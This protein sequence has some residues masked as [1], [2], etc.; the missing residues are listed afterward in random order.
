MK[1][2]FRIIFNYHRGNIKLYIFLMMIIF[3]RYY[4]KLPTPLG[5]ILK[6]FGLNYWSQHMTTAFIYILKGNFYRA[7]KTNFLIYPVLIT[8]LFHLFFEPLFSKRL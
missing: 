1:N 5:F 4:L 7:Y 8:I 3:I 2:Y 6:R